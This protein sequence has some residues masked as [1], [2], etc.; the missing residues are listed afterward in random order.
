VVL[1]R[2]FF[3]GRGKSPL[4]RNTGRDQASL[5]QPAKAGPDM[6]LGGGISGPKPVA[7]VR[8]CRLFQT[9]QQAQG[10]D[11]FDATSDMLPL[12]QT[13]RSSSTSTHSSPQLALQPRASS[14]DCPYGRTSSRRDLAIHFPR[15]LSVLSVSLL[16]QSSTQTS[17]LP[18][19]SIQ[20]PQ[21]LI[22]S[23]AGA[24]MMPRVRRMQWRRARRGAQQLFSKRLLANPAVS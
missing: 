2:T 16:L 14:A 23:H 3:G 1:C 5:P 8:N 15:F 21:N 10:D 13:T 22:C 9:G 12:V 7:A 19:K 24:R 11:V 17:C 6:V 20:R 4:P 18:P